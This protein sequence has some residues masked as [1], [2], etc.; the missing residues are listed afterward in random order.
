MTVC[1]A[2]GYARQRG[3]VP[4]YRGHE[5]KAKLLRKVT[6][7]V[8]VHDD[9]LQRAIETISKVAM[10]SPNGAIGDGKIFVLPVHEAIRISDG[11]RGPEA[12]G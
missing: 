5:Q 2:R 12:V 11:K 8:V 1:D 10:T 6:V 4:T 7:E 3:Q 9:Q